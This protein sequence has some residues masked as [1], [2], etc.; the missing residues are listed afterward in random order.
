MDFRHMEASPMQSLARVA[1]RLRTLPRRV[2]RL[3]VLETYVAYPLVF[4]GYS[5]LVATGLIPGPMWAPV[6][7][8]LM[9]GF[10]IGIFTVYGYAGGRADPNSAALDE[11][12][13]LLAVRAW[14]L[15]FMVLSTLVVGLAAAWAIAVT[16][17]GPVALGG[18]ILLPVAIGVGVYLPLL[19]LAVLTWIEPDAPAEEDRHPLAAPR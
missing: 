18:D 6:A 5:A 9:A 13:H 8:V 10:V 19:P 2:R 15:S 14:A 1:D 7:F 12:Q 17:A 3:I 16:V 11:R 4:I